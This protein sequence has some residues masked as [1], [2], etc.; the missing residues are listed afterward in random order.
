MILLAGLTCPSIPEVGFIVFPE[1][2]G[3]VGQR[4]FTKGFLAN[5]NRPLGFPA[6]NGTR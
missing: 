5:Y 6:V 4:K 1:N 2:E 3:R